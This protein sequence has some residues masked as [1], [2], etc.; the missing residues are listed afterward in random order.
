MA[1]LDYLESIYRSETIFN[2]SG[3]ASMADRHGHGNCDGNNDDDFV[4]RRHFDQY[5]DLKNGNSS[6]FHL[7]PCRELQNSKKGSDSKG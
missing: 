1:Q 4:H 7:K 5:A 2:R 6:S 3:A